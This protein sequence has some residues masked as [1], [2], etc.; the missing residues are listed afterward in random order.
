VSNPKTEYQLLKENGVFNRLFIFHTHTHTAPYESDML[1]KL[2]TNSSIKI[3][4]TFTY[5][6]R[7][8]GYT[9]EY[10]PIIW[11]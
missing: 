9:D 4:N 5:T 11:F 6:V 8:K 7:L 1:C 10:Y 2:E 3:I